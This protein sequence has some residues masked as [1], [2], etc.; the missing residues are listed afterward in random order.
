MIGEDSR[1]PTPPYCLW[2]VCWGLLTICAS[3]CAGSSSDGEPADSDRAAEA[4]P[5]SADSTAGDGTQPAPKAVTGGAKSQ[6]NQAVAQEDVI[7][8]APAPIVEPIVAPPAEK[9]VE[10]TVF[11]LGPNMLLAHVLRDSAAF[12]DMGS[13]GFVKYLRLGRPNARWRLQT[14]RDGIRGAAIARRAAIHVTLNREQAAANVVHMAIH[15]PR[16]RRL[17]LK[18][19]GRKGARISLDAGWQVVQLELDVGRLVAGDNV[20]IFELGGGPDAMVAWVQIGGAGISTADGMR[21]PD[22]PRATDDGQVPAGGTLA[23]QPIRYDPDSD[24]LHLTKASALRYHVMIPETAQ[25]VVDV[26]FGNT[27][28]ACAAEVVIASDNQTMKGVLSGSGATVALAPLAGQIAALEL[29]ASTCGDTRMT[30][31]RLTVAGPPQPPPSGPP[32]RHLII[33]TMSGLRADRLRPIADWARPEVP[34]FERLAQKGTVFWPY[35]SQ[36]PRTRDARA[37][38]WTSRYHAPAAIGEEGRALIRRSDTGDRITVAQSR[39]RRRAQRRRPQAE[40]L[41]ALGTAMQ[42]AGFAAIAVTAGMERQ[43]GFAR[44]FSQWHVVPN[45]AGDDSA[46]S[47]GGGSGE[48]YGDSDGDGDGGQNIAANDGTGTGA[49]ARAL[50]RAVANGADVLT[51]ALEIFDQSRRIGATFLFI[52]TA[53]TRMPWM[54][55]SP[56]SERYDPG[57]GSGYAGPHDRGVDPAALDL[58]AEGGAAAE[59]DRVTCRNT[60][61][62]RQQNRIRALYDS[63]VS[64]QDALLVQLLDQLAQWGLI[65]QTM[66]IITADHGE[67]MWEAGGC[68]HGDT[69]RES[70]VGVPLLI[71][72]PP[73]FPAGQV[74]DS[75]AE[76]IDIL[77]TILR[78]MKLPATER[79]QGQALSSALSDNAYPRPL[80][81]A[82]G[83]GGQALRIGAWKLRLAADGGIAVHDLA[84]DPNESSN[85]ARQRVIVRRYLTDVMAL[86]LRNRDTWNKRTMGTPANM[87]TEAFRRLSQPSAGK[88]DADASDK[89][90]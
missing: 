20:L 69:L 46:V 80:F 79:M 62:L 84:A 86:F 75:G 83:N 19:N 89:K 37:A 42:D 31:A 90:R 43:A 45:Q 13:A 70:A 67:E 25:L 53:D 41:T 33:W 76:S 52:E 11:R 4:V 5:G 61:S 27:D 17:A 36:S 38:M 29:R 71:H 35:W 34:G 57:T 21:D 28:R 7:E 18:V 85:L 47:S 68:G 24:T 16:K 65:E 78:A 51:R 6:P 15:S 9:R 48:S 72:Y 1:R 82:I 81:A 73:L 49:G 77:P 12:I 32:P 22:N 63:A 55:Y 23:M 50:T 10:T 40:P 8:P 30:G 66:L 58:Q 26:E 2:F 14:V 64:Y 54:G 3:G 59:P 74:I 56:W 60:P 88:E 44:G 39:R 87:T